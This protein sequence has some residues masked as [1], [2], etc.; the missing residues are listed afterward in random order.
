MNVSDRISL[1]P[2]ARYEPPGK[3]ASTTI[4]YEEGTEIV[5]A[6]GD[7]GER[8]FTN[9]QMEEREDGTWRVRR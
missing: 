1:P 7:K 3:V 9:R 8:L 5:I 4:V 6:S 2:G